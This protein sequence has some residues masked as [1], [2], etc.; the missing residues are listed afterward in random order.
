MLRRKADP[1]TPPEGTVP[2]GREVLPGYEVVGLLAHGRRIDTYDTYSVERGCRCVVKVLREDRRSDERVRAAV[3]LEGRLTRELTHPHLVR[4]YEVHEEPPA[5]VLEVLGGA[6]LA[7]LVDDAPLAVPDAALLGLQI[8]S[9]LG[10]LHRRHWLH[11]DVKPSNIVVD[12][13]RAVLIDLSLVGRPGDGR[14]GAGTR[15]YLAPE[16]ARGTGLGAATDVWGL[17]VTLVEALTNRMP[18]GDEATWDS[19]RRLPVLHRRPPRLSRRL[20]ADV[21]DLPEDLERA[22]LAS[23]SF[24]ARDRPTLEE[25]MAVLRQVGVDRPSVGQ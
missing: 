18:Y 11:L 25:L 23:L 20:L 12:H 6:T 4:G 16:Q 2:V 1:P 7:A 19:R 9:A 10:Y 5:F 21:V 17:G 15:G 24:D 8:G 13:G 3:L 14:R 22:L